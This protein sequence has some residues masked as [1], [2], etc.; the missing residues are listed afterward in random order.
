MIFLKTEKLLFTNFVLFSNKK[1]N[2]LFLFLYVNNIF[3]LIEC[4]LMFAHLKKCQ[5]KNV[6]YLDNF[7]NE[8]FFRMS[9]LLS[10]FHTLNIRDIV[11]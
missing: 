2:I 6:T 3:V 8:I 7:L 1:S 10:F 9:F 4:N 11:K 5:H